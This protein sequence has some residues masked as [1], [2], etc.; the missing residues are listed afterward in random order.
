IMMPG[1]WEDS[2]GRIPAEYLETE[3]TIKGKYYAKLLKK[4]VQRSRRNAT[5]CLL[6]RGQRLQQDNL[7]SHNSCFGQWQ[8]VWLRNSFSP[9]LLSIPDPKRQRPFGNLKSTIRGRRFVINNG[10]FSWLKER[11]LLA[12]HWSVGNSMAEMYST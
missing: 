12:S 9:T 6:A 10:L 3:T 4:F 11:A 2:N 7:P 1:F 8:E 5:A